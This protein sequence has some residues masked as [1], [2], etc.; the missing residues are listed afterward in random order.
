MCIQKKKQKKKKKDEEMKLQIPGPVVREKA[1]MLA[2]GAK[3]RPP[4]FVL[5]K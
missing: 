1:L 4:F 3:H 5:L 2:I